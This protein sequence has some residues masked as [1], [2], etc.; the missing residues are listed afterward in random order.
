MGKLNISSAVKPATRR[1]KPPGAYEGKESSFQSSAMK[2]IR[3]MCQG[4]G[5]PSE[6]VVH[7]PNGRNA[8]SIGMGNF[9]RSQGVVSGYPDIMV[10]HPKGALCGLGIELKV[11]PN[12]PSPDQLHLHDLLGGAGWTIVVCYGI[13]EV[14]RAILD[15]LGSE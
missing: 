15:Y 2:M 11:F 9:W 5:I 6:L 12:K 13:D 4:R 7:I 3:L 1:T 14:E 10:F 8:G